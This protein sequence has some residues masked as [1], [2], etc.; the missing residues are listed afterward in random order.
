MK[1]T[2]KL[3]P[4]G[5][6]W[7]VRFLTRARRTD[8]GS[9]PDICRWSSSVALSPS[10]RDRKAFAKDFGRTDSDFGRTESAMDSGRGMF[11]SSMDFD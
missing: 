3:S 10:R 8:V 7:L 11:E 9:L 5:T 4:F 6:P 1:L 2:L